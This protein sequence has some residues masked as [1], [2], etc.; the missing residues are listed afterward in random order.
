ME[1]KKETS[2]LLLDRSKILL[3]QFLCDWDTMNSAAGYSGG[4]KSILLPTLV[5][6]SLKCAVSHLME[7]GENG[8]AWPLLPLQDP[9]HGFFHEL[10][11][12]LGLSRRSFS[13]APTS[14]A[15]APLAQISTIPTV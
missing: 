4:G 10:F 14:R 7:G 1:R 6:D 15:L 9:L 2:C 5:A 12:I 11:D 8:N 3:S 13:H